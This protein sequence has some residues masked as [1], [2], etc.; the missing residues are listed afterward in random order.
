MTVALDNPSERS[1]RLPSLGRR[2]LIA[3]A[4]FVLA[5]VTLGAVYGWRG[6]FP[7][8]WVPQ[9]Q[10]AFTSL[11]NWVSANQATNPIFVDFV[12]PLAHVLNLLVSWVSTGLNWLAW[13]GVLGTLAVLALAVGTWRTA[14]FVTLAV[15]SFGLLGLWPQSMGTLSLMAVAILVAVVIGIPLGIASGVSDIAESIMRPVLDL[16][17]MLPAYAYLVPMVILFSIGNPAG[18][19]ATVIYA[20]P[21]IVRLTSLGI[22]T[23]QGDVLE[24]GKA[25][26]ST[27]VQLLYKMELPL[28]LRSIMLGVNQVIMM[29]L[30]V[31]VIASLI[32]TGGLGDPVLQA[33]NILNIGDAF[34]AGIVIVLLAM[35][36]D[37]I[38]G[39]WG[40]GVGK[41]AARKVSF[42]LSVR[43]RRLLLA[44][45][46]AA[47]VA[48]GL[49]AHG[50]FGTGAF[51]A[52]WSFSPA[53]AFNAVVAHLQHALYHYSSIPVVGGTSNFSS[54]A[55]L[56]ILDPLTRVLNA[57]PWW[58]AV[59]G[60][61]ALGMAAGGWRRSLL[62]AA[63]VACIGLLGIWS[64]TATTLAQVLLALAIALAIGIP[65]GIVAYW[66]DGV[67]RV[68]RP[69]LDTLQTMPAFVYLIPVV[70]FFSVGNVSAVVAS[71]VYA[72]A[73]AVRLTTLGLSGV[74][75]DTV[76]AGQAFGSTR[77]QILRKIEVPGGRSALLLAVN[78][79]IMM[80]LAEVIVAGLVGSGGLGYDVVV[81]LERDD[82][83]LGLAA[84]LAIVFL[85]IIFDR[86]TQGR[87]SSQGRAVG[88]PAS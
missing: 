35:V 3:T 73:P 78:Q 10:A 37:R 61:G 70:L 83:G 40:E 25:C 45:L 5:G 27:R 21:P 66:S 33:L 76:E 54:F 87:S 62:V 79:T 52:Q 28:A 80:V 31:V 71:F 58:L 81:G 17:Q 69:V 88:S 14:L 74:R 64:D 13:P 75:R 41:G 57:M 29:A 22:R 63:C 48:A 84:G 44:G 4:A 86:L 55:T 34:T 11:A 38:V 30:S 67:R 53:G 24:A 6:G 2:P 77:R 56:D 26:G 18:V 12:T 68:L 50:V 20:T 36:L 19:V 16:S 59:L 39:A 42:G 51:P 82:F 85:G 72:L 1:L 60:T 32:G 65:L 7:V 49:I 47:V 43:R 23:V 46:G 8:H 15:A 9:S